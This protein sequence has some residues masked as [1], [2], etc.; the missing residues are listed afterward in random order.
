VAAV[1]HS[2][3]RRANLLHRERRRCYRPY[4]RPSALGLSPR[5]HDLSIVVDLRQT[6]E[7]RIPEAEKGSG[8]PCLDPLL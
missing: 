6:S 5:I 2:S 8:V 4:Y 7:D 1:H 3:R